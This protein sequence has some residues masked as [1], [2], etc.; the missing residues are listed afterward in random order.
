MPSPA[1]QLRSPLLWLLGPFAAGLVLA[2]ALPLPAVA[3]PAGLVAAALAAGI[4][5][6][7]AALDRPRTWALALALAAALA[8]AVYLPLRYPH[9]HAWSSAPPREVTAIIRIQRVFPADPAARNLGGL[10]VITADPAND[11]AWRG[12]LVYFSVIRR[13]GAVPAITGRYRLQGVLEPLARTPDGGFNDYLAAIGIR[14]RLVRA[15]VLAEIEPPGRFARFCTALG[16]R[17]Q[18]SLG[19]G[20]EAQPQIRS[21]Y[22]AMLLGEKAEMTAD[23]QN[24]FMRSGT[25]HVFSISGLHVAAIALALRALC[26]QVRLPYP[27]AAGLTLPLLWLYVEVTG[28]SSPA[29]RAF[30]MVAFFLAREVCRLPGNAFAALTAAALATLL[31]DPLQ[32][33]STGFQMSYAVVAALIVMGRPLTEDWLQR[34]RPFA[35]LPPANWRWWHHLARYSGHKVIGLVASGWTAFLASAPAGIG[36]FGLLSTGSLVANLVIVPLSAAVIYTGFVSLTAGLF[37]LGPVSATC[38]QIA[39]ALIVAADRL[40]QHG[41][42]WPGM[43]FPARFRTEWLAPVALLLMTAIMIAGAGGRWV[44]RRGGYWPP[45]LLLALLL[46]L[47]VKFG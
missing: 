42:T 16:R 36:Y 41:M 8:G 32:L 30:I 18:E 31:V 25:Y 6:R 29:V 17:L 1:L 39:A 43:Y 47:G 14:D 2:H 27:L 20:L 22:L 15:R 3:R 4:A 33:F 12:R 28:G 13:L 40:L 46:I 21:L 35:F 24:A 19:R 44:P 26:R 9:L 37:G 23:Q 45:V 7:Q 34:W 11:P 10:G 38:N 5:A